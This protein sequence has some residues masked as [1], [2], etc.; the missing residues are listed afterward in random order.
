MQDLIVKDGITDAEKAI[1]RLQERRE[2][3]SACLAALEAAVKKLLR[4]KPD[5][6]DL[7]PFLE[8]TPY[9]TDDGL[10]KIEIL[11]WEHWLRLENDK[12]GIRPEA[13]FEALG[14]RPDEVQGVM[15]AWRSYNEEGTQ[16]PK[17]YWSDTQ[18]AFRPMPVTKKEAERIVERETLRALSPEHFDMIDLVEKQAKLITY[19]NKHH[20]L[21]ATPAY[22]ERHVPWLRLVLRPTKIA[23]DHTGNTTFEYVPNWAMFTKQGEPYVAFDEE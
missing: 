16:D 12:L 17:K 13:A 20:Y 9:S 18:Q 5:Y 22:L 11:A 21:N 1:E 4:K 23:G 15:A 3:V 19:L 2:R 7:E 10:R 8:Q 14:R 6:P